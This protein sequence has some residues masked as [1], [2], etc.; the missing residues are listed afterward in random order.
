M[1]G[2]S[3]ECIGYSWNMTLITPHPSLFVADS[4]DCDHCRWCP[5]FCVTW[6]WSW[7]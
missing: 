7:Q 4:I 3:V 1:S 2:G 5:S 6:L